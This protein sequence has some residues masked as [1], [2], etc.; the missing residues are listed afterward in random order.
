MH[1]RRRRIAALALLLLAASVSSAAGSGSGYGQQPPSASAPPSISGTLVSGST[2]TASSGTWVGVSIQ[3]YAY[4]WKRCD[5]SGNSCS[6]LAGATQTTYKLASADVGTTMRVSVTATNKNGATTATSAQTA[7]VAAPPSPVSPPTNT[8]L[9]Q[10]SGTA[11]QGQSLTASTGSWS[12]SPTSY[13]YQW[14]RCNSTGG[15]C[16]AVSGATASSYAL[17][18][19]DVNSTMRVLVSAKNAGGT[20]TALSAQTAV[21]ASPPVNPTPPA[22]TALPQVS[23]TAQAGQTLTASTGS[24]S[25]SPTSYAYQWNRCDSAG[26]NCAAISGATATTFALTS[27]DVGKT[28]RASVTAKNSAGSTTA[29]SNQTAVVAS[30]PTSGDV[31]SKPVP[32][33]GVSPGYTILNRTSA[34]QDWE[35][36]QI[37][38]RGA[39]L[40][41][42][43]YWEPAKA[44]VTIGKAIAHGLEPELVIGATMHYGSRDTLTDFQT[45]CSNAATK[46]HGK[47]R[48]YETLN[49]PNIN[50]W[51]PSTFVQ[52]QRACYQ[53]IKAVDSRNQV[54]LGGISPAPNGTNTW[55]TQYAPVTWVQQLYAN[56]LKG[57]F[58]LMNMHL[59]GDAATQAG[60][61][62]W[63]QTFGCG[64]LVSTTVVQVMAA[65]GDS[66]PVVTTESG[67]NALSVGETAQATAV[68]H[69]LKDTRVQQVYVY[70][71]LN[72]VSGFGML[73]PDSAG[74][75]VDPTGAHWRARPAYSSYLTNA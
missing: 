34:M 36:A 18:S 58:D 29:T 26:A 64:T 39:K 24:W 40:V 47:V 31:Y 50:G 10:I 72:T 52:Y 71:M 74:S 16:A 42:L 70:D 19:S 66:R 75:V 13:G 56:G 46:Y 20:T 5:L 3:S 45:R 22:N 28:L 43:D 21:V 44:D 2:L 57:S 25:G 69:A 4:Q 51:V 27:T 55:G 23:G 65:Y 48:F 33:D 12:G 7:V 49:E 15:A 9:P 67:D 37:A 59:Y 68:A 53:A 62:I 35:L 63:C 17:T 38:S 61:S 41:R 6:S 8:G 73:V 60:W 11:Q 1:R 30:A 14:Q 54:L 32:H